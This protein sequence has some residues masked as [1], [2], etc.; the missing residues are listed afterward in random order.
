MSDLI[1][2]G[3]NLMLT[4]MVTVLIFLSILILL[5]NISASLFKEELI[6]SSK[7]N[8]AKSPDVNKLTI[9]HKEIINIIKKRIFNE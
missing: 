3:I 5:I 8:L 1:I 9:E 7:E 2:S 6:D 4:G